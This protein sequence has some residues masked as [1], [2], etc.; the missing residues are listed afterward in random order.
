M[1]DATIRYEE[2]DGPPA[3]DRVSLELSP[4]RSV[5]LAGANGTGKSTAGDA[6]S[7]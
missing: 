2:N 4:G 3:L 6:R 7:G 1:R 5:A